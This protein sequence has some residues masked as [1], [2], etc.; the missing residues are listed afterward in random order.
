MSRS[1]RS[2][3]DSSSDPGAAQ[4]LHSLSPRQLQHLKFAVPTKNEPERFSLFLE[5]PRKTPVPKRFTFDALD[6]ATRKAGKENGKDGKE[7]LEGRKSEGRARSGTRSSTPSVD[8]LKEVERVGSVVSVV[9][10]RFYS[11]GTCICLL[12]L[13]VAW[14]ATSLSI[15]LPVCFIP[16]PR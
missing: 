16:D 13:L 15:V 10:W 6:A 9:D 2:D 7:K 3:S 5:E 11:T 1:N 14:D 12:N 8:L 4:F